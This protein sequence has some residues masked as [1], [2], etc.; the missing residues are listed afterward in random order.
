M[1][2]KWKYLFIVVMG[3]ILQIV[4]II[5][6]HVIR[7]GYYFCDE[8][9]LVKIYCVNFWTMK[10]FF[11]RSAHYVLVYVMNVVIFKPSFFVYK[12]INY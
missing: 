4:Y 12:H 7:L 6:V 5:I 10:L 11:H 2:F 3:S 8:W 9:W 1:R